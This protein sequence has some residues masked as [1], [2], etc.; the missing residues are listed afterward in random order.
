MRIYILG[1][2]GMLGSKLFTEFIK[3]KYKVRGSSR[4]LLKELEYPFKVN[5]VDSDLIDRI[6]YFS[7][8]HCWQNK[9]RRPVYRINNLK[10]SSYFLMRMTD[11]QLFILRKIINSA[12]MK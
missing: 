11:K 2:T 3:K 7:P 6:K 9:I 1:V 4:Y 10:N 5:Y 8:L 12:K